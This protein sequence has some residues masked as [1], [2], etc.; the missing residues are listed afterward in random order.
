VII[1]TKT[2]LLTNYA[3]NK[4]TQMQKKVSVFTLFRK[5]NKSSWK[6]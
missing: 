3:P 1:G 6:Y 2:I 4:R 5:K